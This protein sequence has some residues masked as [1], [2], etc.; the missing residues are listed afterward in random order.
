[1]KRLVIFTPAPPNGTPTQGALIGELLSNDGVDVRVISRASTSAGR[2]FDIAL[3]GLF[4]VACSETVLTNVYGGRAF[5]HESLAILYARLLRKR[6]VAVIRGGWLLDFV[7][8]HPFWGRFILSLPDLNV[9]PHRFLFEGFGKLGI[10]VGQIIPN[11]IQ[12]ENY[13]FRKRDKAGPRFLYT[14]GTHEIYNPEMAVRAFGAI[15]EKVTDATLTMA[16]AGGQTEVKE[17]VGSLGLS[18]IVRFV[19]IVPKREMPELI[20]QHDIYIQSNRVENM[21]VSILE[22]WA[23]GIPVVA[24][25]V[26]GTCHLVNS[27]ND[28][29]LVASERPE[30]LAEACLRLLREP[31]LVERLSCN[32]RQRVEEFSWKNVQ[33]SWLDA[34]FPNGRK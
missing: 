24:T 7:K 23:G 4:E 16:G 29:L 11:F 1:M 26:G 12:L 20:E 13:P 19:G 6:S 31:Q 17:L 21:P 15:R 5:I 18:S 27:G 25:D 28:G 2:F 22:M 30:A 32:G 8:R 9:T 33:F 34:L 10:G 14:R 3:R